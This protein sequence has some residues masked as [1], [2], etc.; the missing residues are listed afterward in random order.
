MVSSTGSQ[1]ESAIFQ[2]VIGSLGS[3]VEFGADVDVDGMEEDDASAGDSGVGD[4]ENSLSGL[5]HPEEVA[6]GIVADD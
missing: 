4:M 2:R 5:D 3:E 6:A 1:V